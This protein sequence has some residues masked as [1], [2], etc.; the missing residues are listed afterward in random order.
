MNISVFGTGEVGTAIATKLKSLGHDAV[1]GSRHPG[2]DR[3]GIPLL[4][5]VDASTHG[6]WI[7]SALHGEDAMS[8]LVPLD[9][10]TLPSPLP[11]TLPPSHA[12]DFAN[13]SQ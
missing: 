7:V 11:P 9:L 13:R 10:A 6:D 12:H 3:G 2:S 8:A 4:S 1:F 5:H